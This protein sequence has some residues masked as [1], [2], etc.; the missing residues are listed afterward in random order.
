MSEVSLQIDGKEVAATD[1]MTVL[2]AAE[3]RRHLN[4]DGL[5]P[6]E[7]Q[8]VR[9]LPALH[10]GS[11]GRRQDDL[12]RRLRLP[13]AAGSGGQNPL[14]SRSTRFARCSRSS[15]WPTRRSRRSCRLWPRNITPTKTVSPKRLP[16]ASCAACASDTAPR[17]SK[18]T[19]SASWTAAPRARSASFRKSPSASAGTARNASRF[20]RHRHCRPPMS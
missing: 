13:G 8:A 7:T 3:V 11:R 10:R 18:N 17:S 15:C 9:R 14:A 2:D 6:R 12:G 4:S 5:P 20:A 19:P 16:S 1:D